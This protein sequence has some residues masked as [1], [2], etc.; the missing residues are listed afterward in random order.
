MCRATLRKS[1]LLVAAIVLLHATS[2]AADEIP[3]LN[4]FWSPGDGRTATRM[5]ELLSKIHPDAVLLDDAG[6]TELG[7][8]DFGGLDVKAAARQAAAT[9][10]PTTEQTVATVCLPPSIIYSMQG[11]FPIEI[12]QGR[13]LLVIKLEYFDQFR[14]VFLDGRDHPVDDY[15]HSKQGHSTGHWEGDTLVVDT[16]HLSA[17]TLLN[18][19]LNH[20]DEVHLIERFRLTDDGRFLHATQEFADPQVLNNRGARYMVFR[21]AEGHVYPYECDPSYAVDVQRRER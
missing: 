9:W 11:P 3:D 21:R 7:R 4:G 16:T 8:G 20:S 13:D 2:G 6:A 1:S 5:P 15:P 10:D 14:V 18:N 17:S 12:F 19:G